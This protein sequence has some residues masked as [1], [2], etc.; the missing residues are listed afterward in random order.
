MFRET[1]SRKSEETK[2]RIIECAQRLFQQKGF[3][4]TSVREITEAAGCAKG[5]FYLY[6]ETKT[7]L[8]VHMAYRLF[9]NMDNIISA[10]LSAMNSDPFDQ[11]DKLL[12]RLCLFA[13]ESNINISLFHTSEILGILSER[14]RVDYYFNIIIE[15]ISAFLDEGIKRGYFRRLDSGLYGKIIFGIAHHMLESAVLHEYPADMISV[16]NEVA[17]IIRKILEK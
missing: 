14:Y 2:K 4:A 1:K 15:K 17:L 8:L 11:I 13:S 7:D 10:E 16:K 5:T 6:F 3:E 9:E 12:G